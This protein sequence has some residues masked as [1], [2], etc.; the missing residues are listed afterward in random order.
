MTREIRG[1]TDR[2]RDTLEILRRGA[3]EKAYQAAVVLAARGEEILLHGSAGEASLSSIFDIASMTKPLVASLFF[4]LVQQG[5][6]SP[7]GKVSEI[8]PVRS[9]DPGFP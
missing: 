7:G 1:D 6:L 4:L 8:L 3:G 2:F 5:T 9:P